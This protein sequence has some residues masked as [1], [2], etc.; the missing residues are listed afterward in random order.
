MVFSGSFKTL[1]HTLICPESLHL[2]NKINGKLDVVCLAGHCD[3]FPSILLGSEGWRREEGGSRRERE[4]EGGRGR[5]REEG[6]G[7]ERREEGRREGGGKERR[8]EGRGEGGGGGR[9]R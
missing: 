3:H 5:K 6:R 9:R 4:E 8:E 1:M 7:K 2:G